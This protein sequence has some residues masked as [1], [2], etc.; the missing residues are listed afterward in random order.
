MSNFYKDAPYWTECKSCNW[1]GLHTYLG[2]QEGF[3]DIPGFHQGNCGNC[4]STRKI[5]LETKTE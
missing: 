4:G 2:Y 3:G 1:L 5:N